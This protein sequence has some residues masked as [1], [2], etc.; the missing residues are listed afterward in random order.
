[1]LILTMQLRTGRPS[2]HCWHT[3][4]PFP[5]DPSDVG[6]VLRLYA[7][8][9]E[10]EYLRDQHKTATYPARC[11]DTMRDEQAARRAVMFFF[12]RRLK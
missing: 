10:L 7:D 8:G 9:D 1:M 12:N 5:L 11:Y 6:A 2:Q 4:E 3:G